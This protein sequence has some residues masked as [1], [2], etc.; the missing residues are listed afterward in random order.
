[1][2]ESVREIAATQALDESTVASLRLY[3]QVQKMVERL[4]PAS[5]VVTYEGHGWERLVFAAARSV[6]PLI[7]CVGYHHAI[8]FP[9]QHA[10]KRLLG[11]EYDPDIICM[12]GNITRKVLE[13]TGQLRD[14]PVVTVGTHRQE[15][16]G[17]YLMQ[18]KTTGST[19]ACLVIP[20]GTIDECLTIL[21]FVLKA[22]V[23]APAI[24]FIIRMHPVMSFAKVTARD[25]RLLTLPEN[26]LVSDQSISVDFDRSRWAIYRGSGA[27]IRAVVAGVRPFYF[28]PCSEQLDIDPMYELDAW[29]YTVTSPE[30]LITRIQLDL[31]SNTEVL[32]QE[33]VKARDFCMKYFTPV[34]LEKFCHYIVNGRT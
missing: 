14:I 31:A 32:A 10:I 28:K 13:Q 30:E 34:N 26:V 4:R 29:R 24:N 9:R 25:A 18:K 1:L 11:R 5:I 27:V 22:A 3:V 2:N 7:R 19:P 15:E 21:G 17:N 23:M 12:G 8:L 20:D 16:F 33:L 6:N